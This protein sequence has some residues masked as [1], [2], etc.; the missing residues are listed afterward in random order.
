MQTPFSRLPFQLA[1]SSIWPMES[2]GMKLEGRRKVETQVTLPPQ[3]AK[4]LLAVPISPLWFQHLQIA[5]SSVFPALTTSSGSWAL[6]YVT[7]NA[8]VAAA[9]CSW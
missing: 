1:S 4:H 2:T 7:P 3:L 5:P 9:S 8:E 6:Y